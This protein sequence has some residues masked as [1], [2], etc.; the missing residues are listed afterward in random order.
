V[1][2]NPRVV[3][4]IKPKNLK[5]LEERTGKIKKDPTKPSPGDYNV[6]ASYN[7]TQSVNIRY[8]LGTGKLKCFVD[9]YKKAKDFLP[10]IGAY[11]VS[12]KSYDRVSRSPTAFKTLR[13]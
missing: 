4:M 5:L 6:E 3:K 2:P 1:D 12:G 10:G 9:D 13:H 7:K 8:K 11:N